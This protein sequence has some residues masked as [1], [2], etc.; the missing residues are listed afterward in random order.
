MISVWKAIRQGPVHLGWSAIPWLMR[1]GCFVSAFSA[2]MFLLF[3]PLSALNIGSYAIN[4]R[5]VTGRYFLAHVYPV[6]APY[7]ALLIGIS[8]GIWTER[9]WVRPLAIVFWFAIDLLLLYQVAAGMVGTADAVSFAVFAVL[10]I[11]LAWWYFFRK[12]SVVSYYRALSAALER[13]GA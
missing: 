12:K 7:A 9:M 10:Y 5:E 8:Y 6:L 2:F 1:A 4:E 13:P 11:A 3:V